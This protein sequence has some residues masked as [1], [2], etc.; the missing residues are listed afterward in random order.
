MS[1]ADRIAVMDE[2][3]LQQ[4]GTPTDVYRRPKNL[5]V[6]QFIGSPVM[7][8]LPGRLLAEGGRTRLFLADSDDAFEFDGPVPPQG[9]DPDDSLMVGRS[10]EAVPNFTARTGDPDTSRLKLIS[11]NRWK[12]IIV[13]LKLGDQFLQAR[14]AS[15]FVAGPGQTVWAHIEESH[16]HFFSSR[17]GSALESLGS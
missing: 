2:G 3:V 7:N 13:D 17:S 15:G 11:S 12:Q 6:A 5:F 16:T 1:L 14:T 8:V 9:V 4:V 10:S